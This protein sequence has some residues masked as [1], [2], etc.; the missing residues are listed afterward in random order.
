MRRLVGS[1]WLR[2]SFAR[3]AAFAVL[4]AV[5]PILSADAFAD[6][7]SLR[8]LAGDR[9][10]TFTRADGALAA[11]AEDGSAT[12]LFAL[13]RGG[14]VANHAWSH[15]G[16]RIAFARCFGRNCRH[17]SVYVIGADGSGERLVIANAVAAV[18]MPDDTHLLVDRADRPGHW[19]VSVVDR[20]RRP[21]APR[22]LAA[23]PFSPR[24]SPDGRWLLHL[25]RI[26]GRSVPSP[27]APHH[28]R[29]RNWLIL[30]DLRSGRSRRVSNERG[31][32]FIGTAPWSPDGTKFTFTR[33]RFLQASGGRIYVATPSGGDI[34]PVADGAREA[35]AWS[36]DGLRLAFNIGNACAIRVASVDGGSAPRTLPFKGCLPT[37]R[38]SP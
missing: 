23:A 11:G 2:A 8:A 24:L 27:N 6:R 19:I 25:A 13:P 30:T 31:L 38:P 36:P 5:T 29:A 12:T 3:A 35:G 21:Y 4:I 22:V 10:L 14:F 28:A 26:Y 7:V 15:D 37:W 33:R 9:V 17:G 18:W 1:A 34:Q 32:Y 20:S 16:S